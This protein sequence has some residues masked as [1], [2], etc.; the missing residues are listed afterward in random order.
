MASLEFLSIF[1]LHGRKGSIKGLYTM[2]SHLNYKSLFQK[3]SCLRSCQHILQVT[4]VDP[5]Q[6]TLISFPIINIYM[7]YRWPPRKASPQN[8]EGQWSELNPFAIPLFYHARELIWKDCPFFCCSENNI[9]MSISTDLPKL[10]RHLF[11]VEFF[12][13][14][15]QVSLVFFNWFLKA[16]PWI[17]YTQWTT[18]LWRAEYPQ[19]SVYPLWLVILVVDT[20][21]HITDVLCLKFLV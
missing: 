21:S 7:P 17:F 19:I 8:C 20:L 13:T 6:S 16:H 9:S 2:N 12:L 3:W 1:V 10:S 15:T 5:C 18:H 14:E 11:K 4:I